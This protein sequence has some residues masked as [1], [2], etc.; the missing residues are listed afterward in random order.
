MS[1]N[2]VRLRRSVQFTLRALS[3]V[4]FCRHVPPHCPSPRVSYGTSESHDLGRVL[5][6]SSRNAPALPAIPIIEYAKATELL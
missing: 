3:M 5:F 2:R 1:P 6:V 4:L